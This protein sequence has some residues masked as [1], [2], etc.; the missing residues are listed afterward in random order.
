[1]GAGA[2]V[3][4]GSPE[5]CS[6]E[7]A[8]RVGAGTGAGA[9]LSGGFLTFPKVGVVDGGSPSGAGLVGKLVVL[10]SE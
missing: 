3:C 5:S 7:G 9:R 2:H 8:L 1:M 6:A 10:P 4:V